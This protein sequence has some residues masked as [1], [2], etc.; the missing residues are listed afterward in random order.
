[1][2][3]YNSS[4]EDWTIC[5]IYT[6]RC[7]QT[8]WLILRILNNSNSGQ[9]KKEPSIILSHHA[10]AQ[11]GMLDSETPDLPMSQAASLVLL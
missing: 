4:Q 2:Q 10:G 8:I 11:T 7:N 9:N 3:Y 6:L 1:M 5:D